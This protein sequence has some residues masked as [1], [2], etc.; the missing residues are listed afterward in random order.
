MFRNLS[1][2]RTFILPFDGAEE[3]MLPKELKPR[4]LRKVFCGKLVDAFNRAAV[5]EVVTFDAMVRDAV[6][7]HKAFSAT[8]RL[9]QDGAFGEVCFSNINGH[10]MLYGSAWRGGG[11]AP[12][13]WDEHWGLLPMLREL[14]TERLAPQY[15]EGCNDD[16]EFEE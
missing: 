13:K 8:F 1:R 5:E 10:A 11:G 6:E 15:G 9:L 2:Q 12:V 7:N 16:F 3:R 14:A 4:D